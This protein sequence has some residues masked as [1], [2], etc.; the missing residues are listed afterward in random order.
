MLYLMI[1]KKTESFIDSSYNFNW[2][3]KSFKI[4]SIYFDF[5]NKVNV[6]WMNECD[7]CLFMVSSFAKILKN[8]IIIKLN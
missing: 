5:G 8:F 2:N 6:N 1:Q 4:K 3:Y 7:S